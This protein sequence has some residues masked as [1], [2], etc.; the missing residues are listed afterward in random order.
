M[1][2]NNGG[3]ETSVSGTTSAKDEFEGC[4]PAEVTSTRIMDKAAVDRAWTKMYVAAGIASQDE[5][6]KKSLRCAVYTYLA[7]NGTSPAAS[8]KGHVKTGKGTTMLASA[9]VDAVGHFEVRQFARANGAESVRYFRKTGVLTTDEVMLAKCETY[10]LPPSEVI[11]LVDWVDTTLGLTPP[12]REA[13][14]RLKSYGVDKARRARGGKDLSEIRD[15]HM[16]R[17]LVAQGPSR[18]PLPPGDGW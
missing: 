16:D 12:E 9:I 17:A 6:V 14:K 15:E 3:K 1:S 11:A 10:D 7:K 8:F 18:A 13:Q 4:V 2:T 5:Q